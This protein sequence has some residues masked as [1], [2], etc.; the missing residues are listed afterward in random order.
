MMMVYGAADAAP[1]HASGRRERSAVKQQLAK[2]IRIVTVAPVGAA[3]LLTVLR[4]VQPGLYA[5]AWR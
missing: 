3:V 5:A 4:A 2:W 1:Y